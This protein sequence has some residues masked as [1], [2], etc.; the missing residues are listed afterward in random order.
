MLYLGAWKSYA[1]T[2]ATAQLVQDP[3]GS[4]F[5]AAVAADA[6]RVA[7]VGTDVKASAGGW[8]DAM[9]RAEAGSERAAVEKRARFAMGAEVVPGQTAVRWAVR[10]AA[11]AAVAAAAA[12]VAVA[13]EP[14]SAETA[15]A[16]G[17]DGF[18]GTA[19]DITALGSEASTR[20]CLRRP[21]AASAEA[22]RTAD[23]GA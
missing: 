11:A 17:A 18:A 13:D 15:W 3:V 20:P 12:A 8:A 14:A 16:A 6:A 5:A 4:S 23:P 10:A 7:S 22:E 19:A 21:P 1:A 9:G 2:A